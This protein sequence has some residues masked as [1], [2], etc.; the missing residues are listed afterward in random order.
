MLRDDTYFQIPRIISERIRAI[1]ETEGKKIEAKRDPTIRH[2]YH[3]IA[4]VPSEMQVQMKEGKSDR[5]IYGTNVWN[6]HEQEYSVG[7]TRIQVD[8][9]KLTKFR[10]YLQRHPDCVFWIHHACGAEG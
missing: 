10:R 3:G 1:R 5:L 2:K 4:F 9:N 8:P 6:L 7:D